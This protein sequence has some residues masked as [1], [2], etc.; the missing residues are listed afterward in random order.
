[1][2]NNIDSTQEAKV[3]IS[4]GNNVNINNNEEKLVTWQGTVKKSFGLF[5]KTYA[6]RILFSLYELIIKVGL[7]GLGFE[8][9]LKAILTLSNLRTC[10]S[11]SLLP[12]LFQTFKQILQNITKENI[13]LTIII[14]G[15]LAGLI[16]ISIEQ[17]TSLTKFI[18]LSIFVR[19]IHSLMLMLMKKFNV[20]QDT[21][22]L[23]DFTTYLIAAIAVYSVYYFNPSYEPM[24]KLINTYANFVDDSEAREADAYKSLLRIV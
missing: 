1:M 3:I 12:L 17:P 16:S 9:I 6:I 19:S 23:W 4:N 11:V 22:R 5:Y 2:I 13:N 14:S 18:I 7:K 10:L 8:N 24:T 21:G 15:F 20:F